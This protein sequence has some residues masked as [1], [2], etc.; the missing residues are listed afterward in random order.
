[1]NSELKDLYIE[2]LIE[3]NSIKEYHINN[4]GVLWIYFYNSTVDSWGFLSFTPNRRHEMN[5]ELHSL[6]VQI[7]K[8]NQSIRDYFAHSYLEGVYCV[9]LDNDSGW[10]YLRP[11]GS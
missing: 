6:Y 5:W 7:L 2:M 8:S 10:L 4:S 3:G 11:I 1:M 9:W